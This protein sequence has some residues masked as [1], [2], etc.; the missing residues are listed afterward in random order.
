MSQMCVVPAVDSESANGLNDIFD[1]YVKQAMNYPRALVY[2]FGSKWGPENDKN[3]AALIN[4]KWLIQVRKQYTV[5]Y[6][7]RRYRLRRLDDR[8]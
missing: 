4:P 3:I 8:E 6:Y 2:A 7:N 1:I 5:K